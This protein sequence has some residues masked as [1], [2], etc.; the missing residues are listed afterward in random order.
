[1]MRLKFMAFA[2][3]I[4]AANIVA[5]SA[6][7]VPGQ[8]KAIAT[9]ASSDVRQ[10]VAYRRTYAP[11]R[12]VYINRYYMM[13]PQGGFGLGSF[14]MGGGQTVGGR[15]YYG[16]YTVGRLRCAGNQCWVVAPS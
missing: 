16:P 8:F 7:E 5:A 15:T 2:I 6:A 13:M 1:M 14:F 10:E 4:A 12:R 9:Q 3:S 11:P